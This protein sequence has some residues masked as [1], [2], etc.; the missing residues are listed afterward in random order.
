MNFKELINLHESEKKLAD[1]FSRGYLNDRLGHAYHLYS[2]N[3]FNQL[4]I[5]KFVSMLINCLEDS[6]PCF[7]CSQCKRINRNQHSD[8]LMLGISSELKIATKTITIEE[9]RDAI[10]WI[11]I[12]PYEGRFKV[13]V[14]IQAEN[15]TIEASNSFLKVL[16]DPPPFA[17]FFLIA[18]S[19]FG[20]SD[21]VKSR[22]I[23]LKVSE[24]TTQEIND[25]LKDLP[26]ENHLKSK[27]SRLCNGSITLL[28][29]WIDEPK[30]FQ[31]YSSLINETIQL[32][33]ISM[34]K[35]MEYIEQLV[36]KGK[37]NKYY[38][39]EIFDIWMM[40]WRDIVLF[41]MKL[42][43][44]PELLEDFPDLA[45]LKHKFPDEQLLE[46]GSL[47]TKFRIAI[48]ENANPEL[49]LNNLILN[50]KN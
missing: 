5:V 24:L 8:I 27:Y 18:R 19:E 41:N 49:V 36:K 43:Y 22:C 2:A 23:S 35:K 6:S 30:I 42:G 34:V 15:M 40:V 32:F 47:M 21:T 39:L 11:H 50:M 28:Q 7:V 26:I 12:N 38:Y 1:Y 33:L 31:V 3:F 37:N 46:I 17:L 48:E 25:F 14:I 4:R 44:E 20:L 29:T 9:I 10:K 13:L 45:E 16:E